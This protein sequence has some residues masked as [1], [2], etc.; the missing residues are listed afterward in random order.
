MTKLE[1]FEKIANI[2]DNGVSDCVNITKHPELNTKNGGDW[3]RLDNSA[4]ANKYI[5]VTCKANQEVRSSDD[6]DREEVESE[7]LNELNKEIHTR[8]NKLILIKTLGF[9]KNNKCSNNIRE[10]IRRS[11]KKCVCVIC[12]SSV[13]EI[14]HKNGRKDDE[15]M[16][17]ITQKPEHFQALCK[18]CNDIKRQKCKECKRTGIRFNAKNIPGFKNKPSF[19][20]GTEKYEGTCVGCYYY[21]IEDYIERI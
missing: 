15:S 10:D 14:D 3:C 18:K 13:I 12:T 9:N 4:L 7:L 19:T 20:S 8:N 5:V 11:M 21:D 16:N 17:T 6:N 1:I 2:D